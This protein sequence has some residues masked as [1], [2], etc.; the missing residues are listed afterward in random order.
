MTPRRQSKRIVRYAVVGQGYI[1]QGAVLPA[2]AHAKANSR[3][4]ALVSGDA[5]KRREL[6]KKYAVPAYAY[7]EYS[8]SLGS[9][10]PLSP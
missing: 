10:T 3:L 1:A 7:E 6:G 9:S 4:V 2:F 5:T 8:A